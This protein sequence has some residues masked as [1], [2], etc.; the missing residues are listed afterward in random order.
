MKQ[1][2]I[3]DLLDEKT[4]SEFSSD[5]IMA[6]LE[7]KTGINI[8]GQQET[9]NDVLPSEFQIPGGF[10]PEMDQSMRSEFGYNAQDKVVQDDQAAQQQ[11]EAQLG[12]E[13]E[14]QRL[15]DVEQQ[16][17]GERP[18]MTR[19]SD[20]PAA[21]N[22]EL[23]TAVGIPGSVWE[24]VG[25]MLDV[26][27]M[28]NTGMTS[29]DMRGYGANFGTNYADENVP[30]S[31]GTKMGSFLMQGVEFLLP[32]LKFGRAAGAT[33][34]TTTIVPKKLTGK[35]SKSK[36]LFDVKNTQSLPRRLAGDMAAPFADSAGK[37]WLAEGAASMA[38]G[39]GAFE[40]GQEFGPTGEMYGSLA[41][42]VPQLAMAGGKAGIE[43]LKRT[44][45]SLKQLGQ[46]IDKEMAGS[47]SGNKASRFIRS[48][49]AKDDLAGDIQK[50]QIQT[51]NEAELS[52]AKLTGDEHMLSLEK[53]A[54]ASDPK[55]YNEVQAMQERTD[56]AVR[57]EMES[58]G[59][60]GR[61]EETQAY[62]DGNIE[63]T[64]LL[65]DERVKQA[66]V[67][68]K[69]SMEPLSTADE[70]AAV[71]TVV[72]ERI[73][74]AK[75]A[76][77]NI[78]AEKWGKVDKKVETTTGSMVTKYRELLA[79]MEAFK[80]SDKA[81]IPKFVKDLLGYNKKTGTKKTGFKKK[82]TRGSY[83]DSELL[84][85]V[86]QFR[87]RISSEVEKTESQTQ[88]RFLTRLR[89]AVTDDMDAAQG[90]GVQEAVSASRYIHD[91]FEGGI[92]NTIYK[93]DKYSKGLD[94][95]LTLGAV[96][97]SGTRGLDA[98]VKI[99]KILS[100]APESRDQL[101]SLVKIQLAN[102]NVLRKSTKPDD[103]PRIN[104]AAAQ[105][106]LENNKEVLKIFPKIKKDLDFAI[107][108][109]QRF[110][111]TKGNIDAKVK[112]IEQS[113]EAKYRSTKRKP[114]QV[115]PEIMSSAYPE[116]E[117]ARVL[118]ASNKIGREGIRNAVVKKMMDSSKMDGDSLR[119]V[120]NAN[121]K[122]YHQAFNEN[123]L[124]RL[125]SIIKTAELNKGI[126][127]EAAPIGAILPPENLMIALTMKAAGLALGHKV[128]QFT[129]SPLA[130]TAG[131]MRYTQQVT[132]WMD[133]G[134]AKDIVMKSINDP[135]LFK[136]LT[137]PIPNLTKKQIQKLMAYQL[138]AV[139]N[140]FEEQQG[141]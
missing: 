84:L 10:S 108:Q 81:D 67:S 69:E 31:A 37:A 21:V 140:E 26:D 128:G 28:Q 131:V 14:Q 113:T 80:S 25:E 11:R 89:D 101:E 30:N 55:L 61:V 68:V 103:P 71:N 124:R 135:E 82:Y 45:T 78:E 95:N 34:T 133:S 54:M 91:T 122:T 134:R 41:G 63:K 88:K 111:G 49:S 137:Y 33:A 53:E 127:G 116:K 35:P 117:M 62:I 36:N 47:I 56:L 52:V 100:A 32:I 60:T 99:N 24:T 83:G 46:P 93:L 86:K 50:N 106:Y 130:A 43:S 109:E 7:D 96:S 123:E 22:A 141:P 110:V 76:A 138:T 77:K 5:D 58:L 2:A 115:L 126:R 125:E 75:Q 39:Y 112:L 17:L 85:D 121:I 105:R 51:L 48:V 57:Q 15:N 136:A 40:G 92:M 94:S 27:A 79:E 23:L 70:L 132:Q 65:L 12:Q 114:G 20:F 9:R 19:I 38:G 44:R 119:Q 118:K 18:L 3:F 129:G 59:G 97:T 42:A 74:S 98:S 120:W 13:A 8:P 87:T 66:L 64:E 6:M 102:S 73:N 16:Q 104:I 72:R 1:Q 4:E 107:G 139:I 29:E 90:S